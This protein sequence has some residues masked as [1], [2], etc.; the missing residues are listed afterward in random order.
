MLL[1][2]IVRNRAAIESPWNRYA[3]QGNIWFLFHLGLI[4]LSTFFF[5]FAAG[6]FLVLNWSWI[7]AERDPTGNEVAVLLG[8]LLI[9]FALGIVYTAVMFLI[10]SF[11]IPLYF[12]Q[13][14]ELGAA[15]LAVARLTVSHPISIL[16]YL[17]VSFVLAFA[18]GFMA[19]TIFCLVCCVVCWFACIPLI[20]S[21]LMSLILCQLILPIVIF[22]RCFQ[23]DCLAQFG[24]EYDVWIVDV[25]PADGMVPTLT[26][27]PQPG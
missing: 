15:L 26:P 3:H 6:A 16:A 19:I 1:D 27:P 17:L 13:S 9:F 18:A 7:N 11:V 2:N 20:G 22:L 10:R 21:M 24:P 23:L 12:K 8:L 5:V 25:P 14:M 4:L